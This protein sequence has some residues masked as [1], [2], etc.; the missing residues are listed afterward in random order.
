MI[1]L[2]IC[3]MMPL[4]DT[5][6]AILFRL[7]DDKG[8]PLWE[9]AEDI[10]IDE[11]YCSKQIKKL[12]ELDMVYYGEDRESTRFRSQSPNRKEHP[13]YINKTGIILRKIRSGVKRK[14]EHHT[15]K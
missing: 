14:I 3:P 2:I 1:S 12:K 7:V 11:G 8:H 4:T 15:S 5:Q 10:E 6:L 9:I 13:L